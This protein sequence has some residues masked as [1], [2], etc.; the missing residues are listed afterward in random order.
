MKKVSIL[1]FMVAGIASYLLYDH[2]MRTK[3]KLALKEETLHH[4]FGAGDEHVFERYNHMIEQQII[5]VLQVMYDKRFDVFTEVFDD[6]D[7]SIL[8]DREAMMA[9]FREGM[10]IDHHMYVHNS[11]LAYDHLKETEW[12]VG[13]GFIR[14]RKGEQPVTMLEALSYIKKVVS[15]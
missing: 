3:E 1:G 6:V 10:T 15:E 2:K 9:Y 13:N 12:F 5:Y 4:V 11:S 8:E 7:A 14:L